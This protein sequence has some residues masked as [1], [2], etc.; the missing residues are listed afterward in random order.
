M[1]TYTLFRLVPKSMTFNDLWI[2]V[3]DSINAAKW[4]RRT[5]SAQ[6][7]YLLTYTVGSG[8]IKPAI[9]PKRAVEDRPRAKLIVN[10]LYT[11]KLC[12]RKDDRTMRPIH[13]CPENFR[14]SLTTPSTTIPI[15]FMS[16]VPIHPMNVPTKFE[17]RSFTRSWDNKGYPKKSPKLFNV[18]LFVAYAL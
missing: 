7:T 11:R 9:Y 13:G 12:Y 8:L 6:C 16:F 4:R 1:N 18:L 17:V 2:K 5:Y 14:D 10:C 15:I 3:I